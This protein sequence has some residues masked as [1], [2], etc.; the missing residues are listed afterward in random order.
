MY[1]LQS[2]GIPVQVAVKILRD[3]HSAENK[4]K[5]LQEAA[6]MRQFTHKNVIYM[7]GTVTS[8]ETVSAL[9]LFDS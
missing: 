9:R 6:I 4:I 1:I 8:S 2:P 3:S 5:F 7:Y